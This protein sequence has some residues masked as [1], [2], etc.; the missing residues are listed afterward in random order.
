MPTED[1]QFRLPDADAPRSGA[2][3]VLSKLLSFVTASVVLVLA[4]TFSLVLFAV[5]LTIGLLVGGYIWWRLRQVR[6]QMEQTHGQEPERDGRV[7]EGEVIRNPSSTGSD[8]RD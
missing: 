2:P 7:I 5:L 6:R 4:L 3:G 1:E 8:S